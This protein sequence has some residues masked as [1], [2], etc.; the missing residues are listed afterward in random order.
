MVWPSLRAFSHVRL[1][2]QS[3]TLNMYISRDFSGSPAVKTVL[4]LQGMRVQAM[5]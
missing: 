1:L 3:V 2:A 4:L 5:V